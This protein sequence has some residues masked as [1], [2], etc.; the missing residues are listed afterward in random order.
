MALMAR[1]W[2][3]NGMIELSVINQLFIVT[4]GDTY[5]KHLK[6]GEKHMARGGGHHSHHSSHHAHHSSHT[7]FHHHYRRSIYGGTNGGTDEKEERRRSV[8][9]ILF[10]I[11]YVSVVL[12]LKFGMDFSKVF[13]LPK[14]PLPAGTVKETAYY[15]DECGNVGDAEA[16]TGGMKYFFEKTGVQPYVYYTDV[17]SYYGK[18]Y[19]TSGMDSLY[20]SLFQDEGHFLLIIAGN[21]TNYYSHKVSYYYG[22]DV[23]R[24]MDEA[25]IELFFEHFDKEALKQADADVI[26]S[27]A[28]RRTADELTGIRAYGIGYMILI[29]LLMAGIIAVIATLARSR[30]QRKMDRIIADSKKHDGIMFNDMPEEL[31]APE[32]MTQDA[33]K[34]AEL[35]AEKERE[36]GQREI[37]GATISWDDALKDMQENEAAEENVQT[38]QRGAELSLTPNEAETEQVRSEEAVRK[39]TSCVEKMHSGDQAA[40][41]FDEKQVGASEKEHAD[42]EA[43]IKDQYDGGYIPSVDWGFSMDKGIDLFEDEKSGKK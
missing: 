2:N 20:N 13:S 8:W 16:L 33:V 11:L 30:Y 34:Q 27:N 38:M 10:V 36:R 14:T 19:T 5:R 28:F 18:Y 42:K 35:F 9:G 37:W 22:S 41:M 26:I 6:Q 15:T 17:E 25:A 31:H 43:D 12:C 3:T 40:K 7:H 1:F 24:V 39:N 29:A 21:I 4:D 32:R 23:E